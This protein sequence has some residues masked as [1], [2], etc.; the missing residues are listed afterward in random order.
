MRCLDALE[1]QSYPSERYEVVVIDN[2][3]N[4]RLEER[5]SGLPR[6]RY[7]RELRPG[8]YVSRN[9]GISLAAHDIFAFTDADCVP[10]MDWLAEGARAL[11]SEP[12]IGIVGGRIELFFRDPERPNLFEFHQRFRLF[13]QRRNIEEMH[14]STTASLFTKRSVFEAVGPFRDDLMS[15]GDR[16]WGQRVFRAGFRLVYSP[17]ALVKHPARGNVVE[18]VGQRVR[19]TGGRF[20][21]MSYSA[22]TWCRVIAKIR[23][24]GEIKCYW[25]HEEMGSG[26]NR[27]RFVAVELLLFA[28]T[29]V[30]SIRLQFGGQPRRS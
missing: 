3:R 6:V 17:K 14:F 22:F 16:E 26:R 27:L 19:T 21:R 2:G 9:R 10:A 18:I 20:R 15:S 8:S 30:E 29:I 13:N 1:S 11:S 25:N 28:V 5:I 12:E 4:G 23:P 24:L 7:A